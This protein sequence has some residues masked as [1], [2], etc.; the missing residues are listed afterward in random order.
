V[1]PVGS[2]DVTCTAN[3]YI[4]QIAQGIVVNVNQTTTLNFIMAVGVE[5]DNVP[6][7]ETALQGNYPNPFNPETTLSY[8][9]KDA[10]PV[11]LEIY[12]SKGQLVRTLV[13]ESQASGRYH[14]L[15]N[16]KDDRNNPVSSGV[17]LYRLTAGTYSRSRKMI[18]MQ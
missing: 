11:R 8:T 13:N 6:V 4:D 2:Y 7:T 1:L 3:G 12:N 18:L 14:V 9:L 10:S 15:W 5:D 17:Y 16:G